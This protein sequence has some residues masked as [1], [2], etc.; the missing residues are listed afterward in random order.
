MTIK[1]QI[2]QHIYTTFDQ[3][4]ADEERIC[5]QGCTACC[6][7][8]V[9][10]T[11]LE[12]ERI[13]R[14]V[15]SENM[16]EWLASCLLADNSP[17][18]PSMTTNAYA[19]SIMAGNDPEPEDP[20]SITP[21]PFLEDGSCALYPVRPFSCRSFISRT[22]C[23]PGD[24]A[25]ISDHYAVAAIVTAQLIE[26][27]G[28]REYWGNMLDVLTALLDASAYREIAA[29]LDNRARV[30]LARLHTLTAEPLPGFLLS[31]EE[32]A[33]I[34]PLLA[35]IFNAEVAGKTV[36]DILNGR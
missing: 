26:H 18:R 12:G 11:A 3:W 10:I 19:R 29:L 4:A 21:C 20:S 16:V 27:L 28:Q 1:E 25:L 36:E 15:L 31:E 14:Y 9:T 24:P 6:S 7:Q 33:R 5:A 30:P 35:A 23:S 17:Y 22:R 34:V 2:L 32:R 13:L 8:N